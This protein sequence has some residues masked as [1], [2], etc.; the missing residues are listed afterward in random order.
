MRSCDRHPELDLR[1]RAGLALDLGPPAGEQRALVEREQPKMSGQAVALRAEKA[2]TVV[3]HQAVHGP[4]RNLAQYPARGVLHLR[5]KDIIIAD[6]RVILT[7]WIAKRFSFNSAFRHLHRIAWEP[8]GKPLT[9]PVGGRA[10]E[11]NCWVPAEGCWPRAWFGTWNTL[12]GPEED[13]RTPAE[14]RQ[15]APA[16]RAAA[17]S[18]ARRR[19]GW[20]TRP[21]VPRGAV[22]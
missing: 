15:R 17:T 4:I 20:R 12:S 18:R 9:R 2:A 22:V 16:A 6:H 21:N 7:V 1:A 8:A 19:S 13:G 14:G 3:G 5:Q 10:H 11:K